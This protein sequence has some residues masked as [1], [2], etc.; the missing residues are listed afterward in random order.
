MA[1]LEKRPKNARYYPLYHN[2]LGRLTFSNA[3]RVL[4]APVHLNRLTKFQFSFYKVL[5]ADA[6]DIRL[7]RSVQCPVI[8]Q[9]ALFFC[10]LY[11][12]FLHDRRKTQDTIY[13]I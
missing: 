1:S 5:K 12:A 9:A 6:E 8:T 2:I 13:S 11:V 4:R 10:C 3:V 7:K